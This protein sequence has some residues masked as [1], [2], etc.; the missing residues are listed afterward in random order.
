MAGED[1]SRRDFLRRVGAVAWV[2]PVMTAVHAA[3]AMAGVET[4]ATTTTS[5]TSTTVP[6]D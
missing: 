3:P 6:E 4:S 5:T 1:T 2:A